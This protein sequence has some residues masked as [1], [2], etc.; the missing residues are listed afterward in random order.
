MEIVIALAVLGTMASGAY[1]GFNAINTYATSTRLYSEAQAAAHNQIDLVLSRAPFN[2]TVAPYKVPIELMT[3][4]EIAT[5]PLPTAAPSATPAITD[6]Y[7][8]YYPYYRDAQGLLAR[9]AFIYTDPVSQTQV[10]VGTL[11]SNVSDAA[12]P[13]MVYGTGNPRPTTKLNVR[14]ASIAVKY[15][16]RNQ[17]YTVALETLRTAD[18]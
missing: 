16:F 18:Q 12:V 5:L 14:R 15:S 4:A 9:R 17:D 1:L 13:D 10:V 2:I 8:R 11:T 3:P 6:P 7:Y